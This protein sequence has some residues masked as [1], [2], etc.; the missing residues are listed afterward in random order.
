MGQGSLIVLSSSTLCALQ[1]LTSAL[2]VISGNQ[3]IFKHC[4]LETVEKSPDSSKEKISIN[5]HFWRKGEFDIHTVSGVI[6]VEQ[7]GEIWSVPT[8]MP[9]RLVINGKYAH[10]AEW[11][12]VQGLFLFEIRVRE[13][14]Q[15]GVASP[16]SI[17]GRD[18]Y[19][20]G[21]VGTW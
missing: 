6:P 16:I 5:G 7:I 4:T 11:S 13:I 14:N 1:S 19:H 21:V 17:V 10:S 12:H 8:D 15:E 2:E 18:H 3:I 9:V 20:R